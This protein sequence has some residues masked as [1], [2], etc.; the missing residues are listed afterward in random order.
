MISALHTSLERPKSPLSFGSFHLESPNISFLHHAEPGLHATSYSCLTTVGRSTQPNPLIV[1]TLFSHA[2]YELV[3][4]IEV[5]ISS[6]KMVEAATL[7]IVA[8][9][10]DLIRKLTAAQKVSKAMRSDRLTIDRK[11]T[12]P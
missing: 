10:K 11:S 2:P 5:A 4:E 12:I 1:V 7:R 9:V 3:N 8:V 6:A